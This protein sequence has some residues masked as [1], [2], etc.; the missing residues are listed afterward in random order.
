MKRGLRSSPADEAHVVRD[1]IQRQHASPSNTARNIAMCQQRGIG[2]LGLDCKIIWPI[3]IKD[4]LNRETARYL[5]YSLGV[6]T[7]QW[8]GLTNGLWARMS[9]GAALR[10]SR[11]QERK[12]RPHSRVG[13]LQR[14]H[15]QPG[16]R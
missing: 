3:E 14:V 15:P 9:V 1:L 13:L 10:L 8:L 5:R 2:P 11:C 4:R 16:G 7:K 6:A 12:M